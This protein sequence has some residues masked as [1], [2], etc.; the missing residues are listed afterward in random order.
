MG[1]DVGG[2]AP[3][4][5]RRP[6]DAGEGDGPSASTDAAAGAWAEARRAAS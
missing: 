5:A 2:F 1:A 6:P 3:A 4:Q